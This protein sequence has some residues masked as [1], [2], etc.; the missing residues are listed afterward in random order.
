MLQAMLHTVCASKAYFMAIAIFSGQ[1]LLFKLWLHAW[2]RKENTCMC[3]V[4]KYFFSSKTKL[5]GCKMQNPYVCMVT[6]LC[7]LHK[8]HVLV[9]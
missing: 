3:L 7:Y 2:V 9:F 1:C 5:K 6:K 4:V 8:G